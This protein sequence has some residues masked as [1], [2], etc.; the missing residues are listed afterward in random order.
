[1][2]SGQYGKKPKLRGHPALPTATEFVGFSIVDCEI[3]RQP[4]AQSYR[5]E[6]VYREG[7][8]TTYSPALCP[9]MNKKTLLGS[10]SCPFAGFQDSPAAI[11]FQNY[12]LRYN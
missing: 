11:S 1:M 7:L 4:L 10:E 8:L 9:P 5:S 3:K 12:R 6:R 2:S